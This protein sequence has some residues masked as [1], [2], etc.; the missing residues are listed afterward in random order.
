MISRSSIQ[1]LINQTEAD[2]QKCWKTLSLLKDG[3]TSKLSAEDVL[4]FQPTLASAVFRLDEKYLA[5]SRERISLV[6]RRKSLSPNWLRLRLKTLA[7]YE[8]AI[9][10]AAALGRALGDS[11]AWIFYQN[12]RDYL[13]KHFEHERVSHT[14][15]GVGGQGELEFIRKARVFNNQLTIYHGTTT[16]LRIG[17]VSFIDLKTRKLAGIGELKTEKVGPKLLISLYVIWPE[18]YEEAVPLP[19]QPSKSQ[20]ERRLPDEMQARLNK[21]LRKMSSS[22]EV[23]EA[24]EKFEFRHDTY[25]NELKEVAAG[26]EKS[27]AVFK[28]AGEGLL[29]IGWKSFRRK[30][31]SSKLLGKSKARLEKHFHG[32]EKQA[33]R[34]MDMSQ[35]NTPTN[36]NG[37]FMGHLGLDILP[38]TIPI[39]W[40]PVETE[41]LRKL[42]FREVAVTTLYNPAH[43]IRQ[44]RALGFEVCLIDGGRRH[45]ISKRIDNA[46]LEMA[47]M[48]YY[49][50]I[51][52]NHLIHE[53]FVLSIFSSMLDKIRRGEVKP[54]ARIDLDIQQ[55]F[56]GPKR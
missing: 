44:I 10:E 5:L 8:E 19:T 54:N 40:W 31:L 38:G 47:G 20:D 49:R 15:S 11:F 42:F 45:R 46:E 33:R 21:Q 22:F 56:G 24:A 53:D 14:P 51:V 6:T 37:I 50:S 30:S 48:E 26:L 43:L 13:R 12:E 1:Q 55:Q 17:D 28:Q 36:T 3:P 29:L 9:K 23:P 2:Y 41:F 27:R 7:E 39:F 25:I 16:F 52:Q 34:I 32:V 4:D 35:A 18:K